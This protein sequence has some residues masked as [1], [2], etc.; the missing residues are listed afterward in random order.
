[1]AVLDWVCL[2]CILGKQQPEKHYVSQIP[3]YEI[4]CNN[5]EEEHDSSWDSTV[6]LHAMVF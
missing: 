1:M 2:L 3:T 4:W 6:G 5:K